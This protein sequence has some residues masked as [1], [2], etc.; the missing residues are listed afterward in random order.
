[1]LNF[2]GMSHAELGER[3]ADS[4][5][6]ELDLGQSVFNRL[7]LPEHAEARQQS[8]IRGFPNQKEQS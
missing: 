6:S 1:M 2:K 8:Y 4:P 7:T 5:E 3:I